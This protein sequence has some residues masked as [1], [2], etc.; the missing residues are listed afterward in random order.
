M[1]TVDQSRATIALLS[2]TSRLLH[3]ER[4]ADKQRIA[5]LEKERDSI[6]TSFNMLE[7]ALRGT[8]TISGAVVAKLLLSNGDAQAI[9]TCIT[10]L[11]SLREQIALGVEI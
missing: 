3:E 9:D 10:D 5:E 11:N 1:R 4:A 2:E 6:Y 7:G 8:Y